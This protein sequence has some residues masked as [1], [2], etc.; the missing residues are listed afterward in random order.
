MSLNEILIILNCSNLI[1]LADRRNSL[2]KSFQEHIH[3]IVFISNVQLNKNNHIIYVVKYYL[4][5]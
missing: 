4:L 2:S 5:L 3:F 1:Y